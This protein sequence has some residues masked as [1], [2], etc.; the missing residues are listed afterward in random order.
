MYK[1][2]KEQSSTEPE[3]ESGEWGAVGTRQQEHRANST[4]PS[5]AERIIY[6]YFLE[7]FYNGAGATIV[8]QIMLQFVFVRV[9]ACSTF[10]G[11]CS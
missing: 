2:K 3:N 7:Y 6:Y 11:S 9:R 5:R 8:V 4:V 1:A 10:N